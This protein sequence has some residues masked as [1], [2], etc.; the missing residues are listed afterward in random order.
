MAMDTV[1]LSPFSNEPMQEDEKPA[2]VLQQ[3]IGN[4][5][6]ESVSIAQST[7]S[8]P[9]KPHLRRRNNN[10]I[11]YVSCD[12]DIDDISDEGMAFMLIY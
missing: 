1:A 2:M 9:E 10:A 12:S 5:K 8:E 6:K 4:N 3:P 11:Y 7:P